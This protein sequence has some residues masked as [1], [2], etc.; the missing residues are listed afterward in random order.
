MFVVSRGGAISQQK[1]TRLLEILRFFTIR[2]I[3]LW[4]GSSEADEAL[5]ALHP[6]KPPHPS[7]APVAATVRRSS[8][9]GANRAEK[10]H[11]G[12]LPQWVIGCRKP[13]KNMGFPGALGKPKKTP[14][15]ELYLTDFLGWRRWLVKARK[16]L[17]RFSVQQNVNIERFKVHPGRLTA[18]TYKNHPF[19][20]ENDLPNSH[21]YVGPC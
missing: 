17:G 9:C 12:W 5:R 19:R 10:K 13:P 6:P 20:K 21:D 2:E 18:G 8:N 1:N 14:R 7:S 15:T 11:G 4:P 16:T 3:C